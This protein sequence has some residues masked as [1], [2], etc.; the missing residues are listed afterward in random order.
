MYVYYKGLLF[1]SLDDPCEH[2]AF[3]SYMIYIEHIFRVH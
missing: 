2:I 3:I 1:D